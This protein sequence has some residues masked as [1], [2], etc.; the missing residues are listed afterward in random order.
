M[1]PAGYRAVIRNV[2]AVQGGAVAGF[3]Y[4]T[5]GPQTL[6]IR[7]FP[8]TR[9]SISVEYR[10][11]VYAGERIEAYTSAVELSISAHGFLFLDSSGRHGPPLSA[12]LLP[13]LPFEPLYGPDPEPR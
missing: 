11:V 12:E 6:W 4:V 2:A 10:A 1:V 9:E 5:A 8:A 7:S 13:S 3:A